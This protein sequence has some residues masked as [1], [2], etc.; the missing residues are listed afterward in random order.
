MLTPA[1]GFDRGCQGKRTMDYWGVGAPP[2]PKVAAIVNWFGIT[3]VAGM[4]EGGRDA[5]GYAIEWIGNA[6]NPVALA[7][8]VSPIDLVTPGMPPVLT[9]HGDQDPWVPYSD[10]VRLHE[11]L[12]KAGVPNE[13]LTIAGG[14]HGD[15]S[16]AENDRIWT[17]IRAFLRK[18]GLPAS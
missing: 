1:A 10:G 8:S 3:D 5:R 7:K 6:S 15:F 14:K 12:K 2:M 17:A 13:L 11:V 18:H 9:I 16:S 4:L